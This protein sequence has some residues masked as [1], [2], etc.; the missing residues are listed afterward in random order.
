MLLEN[1]GSVNTVRDVCYKIKEYMDT[2]NYTFDD[3]IGDIN[4]WGTDDLEKTVFIQTE[5]GGYATIT[6]DYLDD[7]D[8]CVESVV[9]QLNGTEDQ[10]DELD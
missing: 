10:D 9:Y 7:M 8:E 4:F 2:D 3:T 5:D 1:K 6:K